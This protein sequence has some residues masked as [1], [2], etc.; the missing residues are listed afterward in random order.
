MPVVINEFEV[1]PG[2]TR[3]NQE[4][5]TTP[6]DA[7]GKAAPTEREI[8]LLMQQHVERDERVWAH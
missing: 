8:S 6:T 2:E 4:G 3:P 7:A 1:M 5:A